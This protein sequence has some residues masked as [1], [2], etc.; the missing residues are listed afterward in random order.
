MYPGLW[1]GGGDKEAAN[2]RRLIDGLYLGTEARDSQRL[3]QATYM[4]FRQGSLLE[5]LGERG[6]P[7]TPGKPLLFITNVLFVVLP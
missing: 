3:S 6:G 1:G 5:D 7:E 4:Y 2:L